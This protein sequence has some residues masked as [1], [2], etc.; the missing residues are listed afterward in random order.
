MQVEYPDGHKTLC[1][2]PSRFNKKLWIRRGGYLL[3]EEGV[4]QAVDDDNKVTGTINAVLYD[5]HIKELS[6]MPG[7]W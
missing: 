3:I 4:G 1:M 2:L 5:E 6:R 7:V